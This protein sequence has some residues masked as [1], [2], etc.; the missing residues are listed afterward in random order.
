MNLLH[1]HTDKNFRFLQIL[2]LGIH[3][4]KA[5]QVFILELLKSITPF[6]TES[7]KYNHIFNRKI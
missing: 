3:V 5:Y 1:I 4:Q 7:T 2:F 6:F